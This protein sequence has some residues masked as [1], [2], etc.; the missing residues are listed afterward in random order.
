MINGNFTEEE[1][2]SIAVGLSGENFAVILDGRFVRSSKSRR[3]TP[4]DEPSYP[5]TL[6][7]KRLD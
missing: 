4:M 3:H 1:A 6:L 7:K 2:G 5:A